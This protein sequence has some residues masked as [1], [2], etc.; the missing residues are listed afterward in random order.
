MHIKGMN[1]RGL[2]IKKQTDVA[3]KED[4]MDTIVELCVGIVVIAV[5]IGFFIGYTLMAIGIGES[6]GP[7]M[8][9]IAFFSVIGVFILGFIAQQNPKVQLGAGILVGSIAVGLATAGI[10]SLF[11]LL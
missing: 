2:W 4:G 3:T 7:Y 1:I 6:W 8:G 11:G 9:I 10:I 5:P